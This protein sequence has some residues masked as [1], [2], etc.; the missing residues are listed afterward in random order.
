MSTLWVSTDI[1]QRGAI[2]MALLSLSAAPIASL[3]RAQ[4]TAQPPESHPT[5]S[6]RIT[7]RLLAEDNGAPVRRAHVRLSALPAATQNAVPK[8]PY[9]QNEVETDDS[10]AF[11]FTDL[12]GGSYNISVDRT[13]GFVELARAKH[14]TIG[15]GRALDVPIR[16]ERTGAIVGRITDRNGEGLL[17]AEVLALRRNEFRG[18]VTL[19]ADYRS[20]A[21]TND[22]GQFRLF[23]L[24]PGEYFVVAAPVVVRQPA[25]SARAL[26]T[27]RRL[28]FVKTYYPG[29]QEPDDARLI[30]VRSGTNV[31]NVDFSLASGP[32]ASVVI[33]AV[34]SHGQ[35]LGREASATLNLVGDVY[36]SS[37]MRQ[38]HCTDSGQFI[39]REVAPG[40]Y[41]LIVNASYRQEEAA[42]INVKVNGDI[43][44]KAQTNLGAKVSGRFFVQGT[45]P[46]TSNAAPISNVEISATPPPGWTGPS[47][48]KDALIHPQGTDRFELTGLRGPMVLHAQL[49]GALLGSIS[50][51]GG[52]DLAGK[53]LDFTGT[54][55]IDDLLVVF[56]HEKAT[57]EVTLTGLRDPDDPEQVLVMLFSEDSTR[58][59]VGSLQY[60]VIEAS[61]EMPLQDGGG[62]AGR[63]GR[64]FT[65]PLGPVVPG[66]YL[67]AAVPNPGVMFPTERSILERLR[68]LAV[69]VT[70]GA[71]E[72]V[73]V[74]VG[75]SR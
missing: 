59:H 12:P 8:A 20:R 70:L 13:N 35:P 60:T 23:N 66:R 68:S 53:P 47:Y 52:E 46:R 10:G 63:P 37:S 57:V 36:L 62:G 51:A 28:G 41:D 44:L 40:D 14:V 3:A 71:G 43:T 29:T 17:G 1:R 55:S 34:D 61:A 18:R 75:V 21:S 22:L 65:F 39:F 6:A 50:R 19:T 45:P 25:D 73:K 38:T 15:E 33:D 26:S 24:S 5:G 69:P 11:G 31:T 72:T 32:L 49:A 74:K 67:V 58:W 27:A 42:Y 56:T 30:V 4:S 16:L 2:L 9:L 7:G 54:E 48:G 64:V